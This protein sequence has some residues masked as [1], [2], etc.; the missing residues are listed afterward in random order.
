MSLG[1]TTD[2]SNTD[3]F[4]FLFISIGGYRS[5]E[6][7]LRQTSGRSCSHRCA[8][9]FGYLLLLHA[10]T[11]G[12]V[13]LKHTTKWLLLRSLV[14]LWVLFLFVCIVLA[15][16]QLWRCFSKF[17]NLSATMFVC[18]SSSLLCSPNNSNPAQNTAT[19][20][21]VVYVRDVCGPIVDVFNMSGLLCGGRRVLEDDRHHRSQ[22]AVHWRNLL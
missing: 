3:A 2:P 12:D 8:S 18:R 5:T 22:A 21:I 9:H 15:R 4:P 20:R 13:F 16:L 10:V 1:S 7:T 17:A 11:R 6:Y 14:W 19:H